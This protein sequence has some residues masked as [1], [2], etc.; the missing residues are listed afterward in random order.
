MISQ[1]VTIRIKQIRST[2]DPTDPGYIPGQ[3]T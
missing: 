1:C 2:V 3:V